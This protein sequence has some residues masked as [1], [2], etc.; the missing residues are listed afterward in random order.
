MDRPRRFALRERLARFGGAIR[1]RRPQAQRPEAQRPEAQ[2][3]DVRRLIARLTRD[4]AIAFAAVYGA[5]LVL[6]HLLIAT[7][8]LGALLEN[9]DVRIDYGAAWS[10]WPGRVQ[11]RN[12]RIR[13]RE[14]ELELYV[15]A[16][17][18]RA[19][20]DLVA[21]LGKTVRIRR[22]TTGPV[23]LR[24]R[25]RHR[26]EEVERAKVEAMPPIPGWPEVALVDPRPKPWVPTEK[27]VKVEL[28]DVDASIRELWIGAFRFHESDRPAHARGGFVIHPRR[29]VEVFPARVEV[30]GGR[31]SVG[32]R[33]LGSDLRGVVEARIAAFDPDATET[34]EILFSVDADVHVESA[35]DDLGST[36]YWLEGVSVTGGA[37]QASCD[38]AMVRGAIAKGSRCALEA[39]AVLAHHPE[40]SAT[41]DLEIE[42]SVDEAEAAL[43]AK[44]AEAVLVR[45]WAYDW[46]IRASIALLARTTSVDLARS[47][48]DDLRA[49]ID[50]AGGR[51]HDLRVLRTLLP[52]SI[53][54]GAAGA[55]FDAHVDLRFPQAAAQGRASIRTDRVRVST[56]GVAVAGRAR[57]DLE[58]AAFELGP[59]R[60]RI[61]KAEIALDDV[62]VESTGAKPP[63]PRWWGKVAL[64]GTTSAT[65]PIAGTVQA[66]L[67]DA[68]PI[69]HVLDAKD[70]IPGW[71]RAIVDL[72]GLAAKADLRV[73]K[74]EITVAD[75]T[76]EAEDFDLAGDY[77]KRGDGANGRLRVSKGPLGVTIALENG[78][79]SVR[80]SLGRD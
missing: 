22:L 23:D 3:L 36:A 64:T 80:P 75:F 24:I 46:P 32:R 31:L 5:Y 2:R 53:E 56:E 6:V 25:P 39:K 4:L 65:T 40:G 63:P 41:G 59:K 10:L 17:T 66:K 74:E 54:I 7:P 21:A 37:G 62:D 52:E 61:T 1:A 43:R 38:L 67:R 19:D 44:I 70:A 18:M 68:R 42:L 50:V 72:D 35:I 57:A 33:A 78:E 9:D 45:P 13:L 28:L 16:D 58:I 73:S 26:P 60:G 20:F 55:R 11:A 34:R 51:V 30:F 15:A 14:E 8:L 27:L 77:R 48:F 79:T 29:R 71:A 47:D 12:V 69:L 49:S 76:A